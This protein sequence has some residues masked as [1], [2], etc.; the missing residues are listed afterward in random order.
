MSSNPPIVVLASGSP[1]RIELFRCLGIP[2]KAVAPLVDEEAIANTAMSVKERAERVALAK[3]MWVADN[4]R[5]DV[6]AAGDT[7]VVD[8]AEVLGKPRDGAEAAQMLRRLRG[9][10]HR[11]ITGLAVARRG[12]KT[13]TGHVVSRV[14]M[15]Q[16]SDS[17]IKA[18]VATG[19]PMDKAGAYGVQDRT[20]HPAE[21]VTGCYLNVVGLPVCELGHMLKQVGVKVIL[22][23]PQECGRASCKPE[24]PEAASLR[25]LSPGRQPS[26]RSACP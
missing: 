1:R 2:F 4:E 12:G 10:E 21:K 16:Y 19:D 18:Y 25:S 8:D 26:G 17:E 23:L 22:D 6:V 7:I 24:L 13:V 3:A 5:A 11:V 14:K 9:R 20:F 15:R